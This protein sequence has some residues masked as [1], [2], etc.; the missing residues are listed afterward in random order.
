ME[1]KVGDKFLITTGDW[2]LAPDGESYKAVFG[3]LKGIENSEEILKIKTNEKSTNWYLIIGN[4]IIA[5]CQIHYAIRTDK[6]NSN[7]VDR[8]IEHRGGIA[9]AKQL[10]TRI[11]NADETY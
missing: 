2:F 10:I 11:Y 7:A 5:G 9:S 4:M 3:T 8:E 1:Y 6:F